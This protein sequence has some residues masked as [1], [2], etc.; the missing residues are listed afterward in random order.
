[1]KSDQLIQEFKQERQVFKRELNTIDANTGQ[2]ETYDIALVIEELPTGKVYKIV[3]NQHVVL[4][5]GDFGVMAEVLEVMNN[6]VKFYKK[7]N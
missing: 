6:L 7:K 2:E 4:N 5:S 1:M 3:M